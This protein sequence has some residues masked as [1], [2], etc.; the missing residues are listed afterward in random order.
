MWSRTPKI[1]PQTVKCVGTYGRLWEVRGISDVEQPH[2]V[3]G[4]IEAEGV[5]VQ[6][7]ISIYEGEKPLASQD[8][9]AAHLAMN[10]VPNTN[11]YKLDD[12]DF[13]LPKNTKIMVEGKTDSKEEF[14]KY[15]LVLKYK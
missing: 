4:W 14:P 5:M 15:T 3:D 2:I 1:I 12:M 6:F 9:S 13:T 11:I 8:Y 10:R 7:A